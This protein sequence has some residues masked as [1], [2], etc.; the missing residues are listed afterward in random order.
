MRGAAGLCGEAVE[1]GG[2]EKHLSCLIEERE[3]GQGPAAASWVS[4]PGLC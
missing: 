2:H 1:G 3:V 4:L